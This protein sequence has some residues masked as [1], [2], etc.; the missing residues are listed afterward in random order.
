MLVFMA[1][2]DANSANL[3]LHDLSS[4]IFTMPAMENGEKSYPECPLLE[5][6]CWYIHDVYLRV[7]VSIITCH[8]DPQRH[9]K[10]LILVHLDSASHWKKVNN[11]TQTISVA[12]IIE[13]DMEAFW[14]FE[15][16]I[17]EQATC[18]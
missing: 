16:F 7:C 8:E 5:S 14:D 10:Q 1:N 18:N 6:H 11:V 2:N 9:Q 3:G 4:L 15:I 13:Y 17:E 12:A